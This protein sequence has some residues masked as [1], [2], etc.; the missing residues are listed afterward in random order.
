MRQDT[1]DCARPSVTYAT[2]LGPFFMYSPHSA[3]RRRKERNHSMKHT[4]IN[5]DQTQNR[6]LKNLPPHEQQQLLQWC[7]LIDLP[8]KRVLCEQGEVFS[9]V[10]F[11]HNSVVSMVSVLEDG[12]MV[13]VATIGNEGFVGVP[14]LLGVD[15]AVARILVQVPGRA[16]RMGIDAFRE[17]LDRCPRLNALAHNYAH[18]LLSQVTRSGGCNSHHSTEERCA[19]WLLMT[20]DRAGSLEIPYTQEFLATI[21][22][23]SRPR[24]NI[25]IGVLQKAGL[26]KATKGHI[27][28][29]DRQGLE[30]ASCECYRAIREEFD[31]FLL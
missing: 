29:V 2:P 18:A 21:L 28:I 10:Y 22:N 25:A 15:K 11:P 14:V 27:E 24:M 7:S 31:R 30:D 5:S 23:V 13:E 3:D 20:A 4:W 9:C 6:L 16:S 1:V 12:A 19:R 17:A 8:D 26:I